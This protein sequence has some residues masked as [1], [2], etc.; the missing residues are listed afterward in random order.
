LI[1]FISSFKKD[2][3]EKEI[4]KKYQIE[5]IKWQKLVSQK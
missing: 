1:F 3:F 2:K 4:E 5:E